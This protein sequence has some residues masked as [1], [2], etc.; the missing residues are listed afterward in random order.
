M[1]TAPFEKQLE[2]AWY[3]MTSGSDAGA[4][5]ALQIL[6]TPGISARDAGAAFVRHFERPLRDERAARGALAEGFAQRFGSGGTG[7]VGGAGQYDGLRIKGQQAIAGGGAHVGVT[8]LARAVQENLPGGVRHFAAIND[9]YH[10]GTGSKHAKGLAFDT[11]LIDPRQ[12][13]VA[14][15]AIRN[16]LRGAGLTD[17]MFRVIDEYKNPSARSTGGHIHTQFN[18]PEAAKLYQDHVAR[19]RDAAKA[20]AVDPDRFK[21]YG[22]SPEDITRGVPLNPMRMIDPGS[23]NRTLASGGGGGGTP[24]IN[25]NGTNGDPETLANAVQKRL[26]EQYERRTTDLEHN[27]G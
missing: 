17:S 6:R 3:E 9:R 24:V 2:G 22:A 25:I 15:E 10:A 8:D 21:N 4:K 20:P 27:W 16:R 5:R 19:S 11:S 23:F 1:S 18:S 26:N 13:A 7:S 14:A 12:S